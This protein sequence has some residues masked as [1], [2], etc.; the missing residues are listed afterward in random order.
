MIGSNTLNERVGLAEE[1][2][3]GPFS[4]AVRPLRQIVH[5]VN[6]S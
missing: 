4:D 6:E 3:E 1:V 5:P 2:V